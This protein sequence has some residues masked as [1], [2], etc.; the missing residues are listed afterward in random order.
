M[1]PYLTD[2]EIA[3]ICEP[4]VMPAAQRRFLAS[5]GLVVKAK[6][7]G[8]ALVARAELERVLVGRRPD[9]P[10]P[11][12]PTGPNVL[13]LDQWSKRRKVSGQKSQGR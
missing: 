5:L 11:N 1:S 6:P 7:N 2:A 4:L 13:G 8:R 9:Q 3:D 12:A 10:A